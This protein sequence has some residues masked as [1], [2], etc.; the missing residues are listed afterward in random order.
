MII[1]TNDIVGE[2]YELRFRGRK[3]IGK[4]QRGKRVPIASSTRDLEKGSQFWFVGEED[5]SI[6]V[7][8]P[9]FTTFITPKGNIYS[10]TRNSGEFVV[11]KL[12]RAPTEYREIATATDY[13]MPDGQMT[14]LY[15]E[16]LDV[17]ESKGFY[18]IFENDG[19]KGSRHTVVDGIGN[20]Y[21][22]DINPAPT[23]GVQGFTAKVGEEA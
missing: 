1:D 4:I 2:R 5:S 19:R 21:L 12:T 14:N 18:A 22:E 13:A 17:R 23:L 9:Y 8:L 20:V 6:K 10:W 15:G 16:C 7:R 3:L 11:A